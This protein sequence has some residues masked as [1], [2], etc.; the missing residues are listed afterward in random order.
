MNNEAERYNNFDFIQRFFMFYHFIFLAD[1]L[2]FTRRKCITVVSLKRIQSDKM[3]LE[4]KRMVNNVRRRYNKTD[5][6]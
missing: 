3:V 5:K 1:Y 6:E 4:W 2:P